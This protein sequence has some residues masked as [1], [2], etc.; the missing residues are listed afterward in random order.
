MHRALGPL[1]LAACWAALLAPATPTSTAVDAGMFELV[2][3]APVLAGGRINTSRYH[4]VNEV[5]MLSNSLA[6]TCL[7]FALE[8]YAESIFSTEQFYGATA[9]HCWH[10]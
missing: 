9:G 7:F 3:S 4:A 2:F 6:I 1:R 8:P 10:P 5:Q